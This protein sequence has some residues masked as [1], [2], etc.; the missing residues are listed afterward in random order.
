MVALDDSFL[1]FE[2]RQETLGI[3]LVCKGKIDT[4][5]FQWLECYGV[6]HHVEITE[7]PVERRQ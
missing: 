6:I 2:L 5:D 3:E 4:E 7:W 1:G